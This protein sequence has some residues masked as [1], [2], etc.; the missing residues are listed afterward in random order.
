MPFVHY[1]IAADAHCLGTMYNLSAIIHNAECVFRQQIGKMPH[2]TMTGQSDIFSVVQRG[3]S[4][5][6]I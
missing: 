5:I 3:K 6:L 2:G 1:G 4:L